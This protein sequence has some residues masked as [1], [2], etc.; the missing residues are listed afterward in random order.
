MEEPTKPEVGD[1]T[2]LGVEGNDSHEQL[3]FAQALNG[4]LQDMEDFMGKI[5]ALPNPADTV[6]HMK[7]LIGIFRGSFP[8][9]KGPELEGPSL[10]QFFNFTVPKVKDVDCSDD[11]LAEYRSFTQTDGGVGRSATLTDYL[12]ARTFQPVVQQRYKLDF[13]VAQ[14]AQFRVD[15]KQAKRSVGYNLYRPFFNLL[16]TR[17]SETKTG[18]VDANSALDDV[19]Q[20][21]EQSGPVNSEQRGLNDAAEV[22]PIP[23]SEKLR[24]LRTVRRCFYGATKAE[25]EYIYNMEN[26]EKIAED[27]NSAIR[28]EQIFGESVNMSR[29]NVAAQ[30]ELIEW[31][32]MAISSLP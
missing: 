26:G 24:L 17:A 14:L 3:D 31:I 22:P 28:W 4:S 10:S 16:H 7:S 8:E 27:K 1:P 9:I 2:T 15:L 32:D 29:M 21:I 6:L 18:K 20:I 5:T 25:Q 13:T 30:L 19:L 11:D 12:I 23:G